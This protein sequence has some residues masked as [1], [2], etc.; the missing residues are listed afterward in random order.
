MKQPMIHALDNDAM[1]ACQLRVDNLTKPLHS[2]AQLEKM[3]VRLAGIYGVPQPNHIKNAVLIVAGDTAVDGPQNHTHGVESLAAVKRLAS[4]HSVTHG[5][6]RKLD[7]DVTI[8]NVG[9]ELP[10]DGI[11]GVRDE[12]VARGAHFFAMQPAMSEEDL[13]KALALGDQLADEFYKKGVQAVALGSVGERTFLS[14]LAVTAAITGYP[15]AQLLTDNE[16]TLS[17]QEKA[18][19]LTATMARYQ[20]SAENPLHVLQT[21]GTPEIATLTAFILGAAQRRMAVVIDTAVTGAALLLATA[22]DPLAKD[23]A[24]PSAV[25]QEPIHKSQMKWLGMHGFL[26]YNFTMDEA[27]GS[28]LGLSLLDASLHMLNDMKTFGEA[29]VTVAEDGPGNKRQDGR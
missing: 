7:A 28:V 19:R 22:I 20:L 27:L 18:E 17:I 9:L 1:E 29:A 23:F 2:L 21:V 10:V 3:A 6:A 12:H 13:E 15:M 4:G 24:F 5:A 11:E 26:H 25:F 8:V 14:A 16:C